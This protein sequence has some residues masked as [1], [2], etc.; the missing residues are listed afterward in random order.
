MDL[1]E[2]MRLTAIL[3]R[4][5]KNVWHA[6]APVTSTRSTRTPRRTSAWLASARAMSTRS[7][8]MIAQSADM[9]TEKA[10]SVI[11]VALKNDRC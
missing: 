11:E 4:K 2:Q 3:P 9:P 5:K 6:N 10:E 7:M 8:H 1:A